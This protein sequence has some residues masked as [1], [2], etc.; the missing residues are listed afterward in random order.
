MWKLDQKRKFV[1]LDA[2]KL[3]LSILTQN[4]IQL[5]PCYLF[6]FA[7]NTVQVFKL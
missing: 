3:A 5:F 7:E 2:L 4:R 1:L 6:L